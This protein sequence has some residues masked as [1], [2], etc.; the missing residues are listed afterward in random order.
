[1]AWVVDI[2]KQSLLSYNLELLNYDKLILCESIFNSYKILY[3]E[4]RE[5]IFIYF[6][7]HIYISNTKIKYNTGNKIFI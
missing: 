6:I 2:K 5:K 3:L 1:M 4:D 7:W